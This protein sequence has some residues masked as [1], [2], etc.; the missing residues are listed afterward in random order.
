MSLTDF[1]VS[2]PPNHQHQLTF[3][4]RLGRFKPTE[5]IFT[6]HSSLIHPQPEGQTFQ[7]RP[8]TLPTHV[9]SFI[10]VYD[11]FD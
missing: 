3:G 1:M 7:V 11:F 10:V 4:C 8:S 2:T 9:P 5:F 6:F